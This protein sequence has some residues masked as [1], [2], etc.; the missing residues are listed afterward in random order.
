MSPKRTVLIV[1][2]GAAL[3]AWIAA[4]ATPD[5]PQPPPAPRL[6]TSAD[7]R[8]AELARE[9]ARLHARLQP[10]SAP[11]RPGRNLFAFERPPATLRQPLG[12]PQASAP[13]DLP[14]APVA[15]VFK[16][17]GIAED[18]GVEGPVRTAIISGLGQLFLVKE[19]DP[20]TP[21]YK[22]LKIGA[23]AVE[24]SDA[25]GDAPIRLALR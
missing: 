15:P 7:A 24:L 6:Q 25:D 17:D 19:G 9:V 16:L 14:P 3:A 20:L 5:S 12:P 23:D 21:R 4:A 8:G 22:V 10:L 13:A 1:V 18:P 11:H 2:G